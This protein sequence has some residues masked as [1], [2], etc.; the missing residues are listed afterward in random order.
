MGGHF[1]FG[2]QSG[3]QG[4]KGLGYNTSTLVYVKGTWKI[5]RIGAVYRVVCSSDKRGWNHDFSITDTKSKKIA[6]VLRES[7]RSKRTKG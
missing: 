4:R 5:K 1:R 6:D 3:M 7:P 2:I